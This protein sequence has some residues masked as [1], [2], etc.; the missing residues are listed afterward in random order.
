MYVQIDGSEHLTNEFI[1]MKQK[2]LFPKKVEDS[3]D[4]LV[5]GKE[6][7]FE[8]HARR[9]DELRIYDGKI[10]ARMLVPVVPGVYLYYNLKDTWRNKERA[11]GWKAIDTTVNLVGEAL[12][13]TVRIGG[14]YLIYKMTEYLNS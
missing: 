2:T 5:L 12:L 14:G 6:T 13:D 8:R 1:T 11:V 10:L 7:V 4:E 3:I 9:S